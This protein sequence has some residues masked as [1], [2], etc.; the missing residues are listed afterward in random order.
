MVAIDNIIWEHS[1]SQRQSCFKLLQELDDLLV[2]ITSLT[3]QLSHAWA[4]D[5]V[6]RINL[7]AEEAVVKIEKV[8]PTSVAN[9]KAGCRAFILQHCCRT[10][11]FCFAYP[12]QQLHSP[13]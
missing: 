13:L 8:R 1:S 7:H 5:P 3:K 10:G 4:L 2:N 12:L 11:S 9:R 6:L